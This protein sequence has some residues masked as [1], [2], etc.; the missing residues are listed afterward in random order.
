MLV[1]VKLLF[2][3]GVAALALAVLAPRSV[4][5]LLALRYPGAIFHLE[6]KDRVIALAIDD[7]PDPE[8]SLAI[9]RYL[10]AEGIPATFFV[11][12]E[13]AEGQADL[14]RALSALGH[15]I[16]AHFYS[17]EV[18]ARLPRDRVEASLA[19]TLA[20]I[21][22]DVPVRLVRPGFGLPSDA[23]VAVAHGRGLRLVVG[24]VPGFDAWNPPGWLLRAYFRI[25]VRPGSIVTLHEG[26]ARGARTLARL[27][28][29]LSD[30]RQRGFVFVPI[31]EESRDE[32]D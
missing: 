13:R 4:T 15:R 11:I 9:G 21:P 25:A 6:R 10:A 30:L 24:D 5:A 20:A 1:G 8:A 32:H 31:E 16:G 26:G 2:F 7:G 17:D 22:G 18:T 27:P 23:A 12:G 28:A 3:L 14:L 29:I 19:A